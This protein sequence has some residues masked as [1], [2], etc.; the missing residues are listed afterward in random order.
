MLFIILTIPHTKIHFTIY[1][2]KKNFSLFLNDFF[3]IILLT[4]DFMIFYL[5]SLIMDENITTLEKKIDQLIVVCEKLRND[6]ITIRQKYIHSESEND[7]LKNK[8]KVV[9]N[10]IKTLIDTN[11]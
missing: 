6:N 5:Y 11:V 7:K 4:I 2:T 10:R 1:F 3:Q 9:T 8:I